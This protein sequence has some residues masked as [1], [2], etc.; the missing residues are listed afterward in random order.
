LVL[1]FKASVGVNIESHRVSLVY[2][3]KNLRGFSLGGHAVYPLKKEE[4]QDR[5]E[6]IRTFVNEFLKIHKI[7]SADIFLGIQ[8]DLAILR[9]IEFP[10][11]VKENLRGALHY[12]ME[13]YV[14]LPVSDIYFDFHIISE[15]K[16]AGQLNVMLIA[17][18][19]EVIDS[20]LDPERRL[21]EGIAGIEIHSTA[22]VNYLAGESAMPGRDVYAVL[23][24]ENDS[25]EL[26]LVKKK[27]LVY[28]RHMKINKSEGRLQSLVEEELEL[29]KKKF[30]MEQERLE[31]VACGTDADDVRD[32]FKE[33]K[34]IP[35]IFLD[36]SGTK[37]PSIILAT[38]YGLALKMMR[39]TPMGINLIPVALRKKVSKR[40]YY[41]MLFLSVLLIASILGW[42]GSSVMYQRRVSDRL[43]GELKRLETEVAAVNKTK[44]KLREVEHRVDSLNMLRKRHVPVLNVL[45]ELTKEIPQGAWL[46]RLAIT[47]KGG[48]MEG[49]AD[50]A[51]VLIPRLAASPLLKDVAFLSPITKNKDG[52][53]RFR[54]GFNVR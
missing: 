48:D 11:A 10:L 27:L 8:R 53:E 49:Y 20:F 9:Y 50:S 45:L 7:L 19:K 44:T 42:A 33:R 2:L 46:E 36:P 26:G 32:L 25:F 28:S 31:V 35:F 47:D 3:K 23:S 22:L 14:S 29:L 18:K 34:D 16:D 30:G 17:V 15:N 12:E 5:T 41:V 6:E 40:A 4:A 24:M 51:S 21:G 13:K 54:I 52:K 43:A 38:A 39:Q 1:Y 37:I